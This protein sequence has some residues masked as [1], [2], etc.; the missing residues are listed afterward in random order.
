MC[1]GSDRWPAAPSA[2]LPERRRVEWSS[3][4]AR[5]E[6]VGRTALTVVS[7]LTGKKYRFPQPGVQVEV[8][9]RDQSWIAFV[10][11]LKRSS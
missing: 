5:F 4:A 2:G 3:N 1:C 9:P 10:P 8:D 6:Y 7:P 11:N